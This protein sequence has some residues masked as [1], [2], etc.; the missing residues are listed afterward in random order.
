MKKLLLLTLLFSFLACETDS[1]DSGLDGGVDSLLF[2]EVECG[3]MA[4]E[5]DGIL[6]V[7]DD[8]F[9][10]VDQISICRV[11]LNAQLPGPADENRLFNLLLSPPEA[12]TYLLEETGLSDEF[13]DYTRITWQYSLATEPDGPRE[14][15]FG[16]SSRAVWGGSGYLEITELVLNFDDEE[17]DYISGQFEYTAGQFFDETGSAPTSVTIRGSFCEIPIEDRRCITDGT[18]IC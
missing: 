8:V 17:P 16:F 18:V 3:Q 15:Q 5:I 2:P 12:G 13:C 10:L 6:T 1:D 7:Y 11:I 14:P 9:S 4:L